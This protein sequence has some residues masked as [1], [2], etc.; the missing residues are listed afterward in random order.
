M[1][2]ST[3]TLQEGSAETQNEV[4][5]LHQNKATEFDPDQF[6]KQTAMLSV[7]NAVKT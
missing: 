1:Q 4:K 5:N 3:T 2:S 6:D 7:D